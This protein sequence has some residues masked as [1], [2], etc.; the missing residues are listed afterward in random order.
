MKKTAKRI[1]A[2]IMCL[3]LVGIFMVPTVFAAEPPERATPT[4]FDWQALINAALAVLTIV[5]GFLTLYFK[6]RADIKDKIVGYINTAEDMYTDATKQ[7]GRRYEW[8][9]DQLY[10]FI[11]AALRAVIPRAWIGDAVQW[12]FNYMAEFAAKQIDKA[13]PEKK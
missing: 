9:V 13:L 7:G 6:K 11:P 12:V 2:L 3:L 10:G 5:G 4:T 1:I 8:V